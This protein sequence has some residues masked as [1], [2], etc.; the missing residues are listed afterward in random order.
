MFKKLRNHGINQTRNR[1]TINKSIQ[2][3][4][5]VSGRGQ[6]AEFDVVGS[7]DIWF[8]FDRWDLGDCSAFPLFRHG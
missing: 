6:F 3:S 1:N 7:G 8:D 4:L 5:K 2:L